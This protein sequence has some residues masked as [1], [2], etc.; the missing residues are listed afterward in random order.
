M[1]TRCVLIGSPNWSQAPV[2]ISSHYYGQRKAEEQ[3]NNQL[4]G[5]Q[6][7]IDKE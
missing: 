5:R 7:A 3:E 1:N 4:D 6:F 2:F